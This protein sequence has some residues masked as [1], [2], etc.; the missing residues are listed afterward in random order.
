M[1]PKAIA[2]ER[3]RGEREGQEEELDQKDRKKGFYL[4]GDKGR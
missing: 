4:K 2:A 1:A 3:G